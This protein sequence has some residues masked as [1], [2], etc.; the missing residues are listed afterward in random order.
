MAHNKWQ[1]YDWVG[2]IGKYIWD[3]K[4]LLENTCNKVIR[5]NTTVFVSGV[6]GY[7]S[8]LTVLQ[9]EYLYPD[10]CQLILTIA[11]WDGLSFSFCSVSL[12]ANAFI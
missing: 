6:G 7:T 4:L 11:N 2:H 8:A 9:V 1:S 10:N 12:V 5:S 3:F